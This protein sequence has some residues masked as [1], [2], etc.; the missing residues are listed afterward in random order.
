[1]FWMSKTVP[2]GG[3]L[4]EERPL[5]HDEMIPQ[6]YPIERS[7]GGDQFVPGIGEDDAF[8]KRVDC[9]VPDA[10]QIARSMLTCR[11][12]TPVVALFVAG[13]KRFRQLETMMSKS[14]SRRRLMYCTSSTRRTATFIPIR[15]SAG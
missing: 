6:Q 1:M 3:A 14:H 5:R 9:R 4:V 12:R 8:D 7:G 13:R 15:S 2:A 11:V 10:D